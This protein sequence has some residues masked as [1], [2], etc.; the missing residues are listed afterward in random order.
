M[1]SPPDVAAC[2]IPVDQY[3]H[4][5]ASAPLAEAFAAIRRGMGQPARTGFRRLL[6]IDEAGRL[7]GTAGMAELL[8]GLE[9]DMLQATPEGVAQGFATPFT[10]ES[11]VALEL[12]WERIFAAGMP[13]VPTATVASVARPIQFTLAPH[14]SLGRALHRMLHNDRK[15]LP[16]VADERVLGV[17]R[18]VDIFDRVGALIEEAQA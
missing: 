14:D 13:A 3:P 18:L 7:V 15:M 9:P 12:Y 1:S 11:D 6:I 8:R 17:I 2:M 5:A 10:G 16:V 4:V